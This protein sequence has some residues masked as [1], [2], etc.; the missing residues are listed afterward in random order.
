MLYC[1]SL[2]NILKLDYTQ[3]DFINRLIEN[4]PIVKN[5]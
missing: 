4:N 2:E 3:E 5:A 1:K